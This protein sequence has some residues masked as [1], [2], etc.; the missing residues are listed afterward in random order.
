MRFRRPLYRR[1]G[2]LLTA[3][4]AG[5]VPLFTA[6]PAMAAAST[7][8]DPVGVYVLT[9][10]SEADTAPRPAATSTLL[11]VPD[12]GT[13]ADAA[14]ACEQ[15]S[16][17]N[18]RVDRVPAAP[19]PCTREYAPV[20]VAA[21]GVWNRQRREFTRTYPNRCEAIRATGGVIFAFRTETTPTVK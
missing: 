17:T 4:A 13:H 2:W 6:A 8:Y 11:C 18:G 10:T 3:A 7:S 16:R 21:T 14:A 5:L 9:V 12:G 15:L 1:G 20:R 19:G